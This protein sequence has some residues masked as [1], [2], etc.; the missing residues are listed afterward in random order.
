MHEEIIERSDG[1]VCPFVHTRARC[2]PRKV[3]QMRFTTNVLMVTLASTIVLG[4]A[5]T[6]HAQNDVQG[7]CSDPW[8]TKAIQELE[9]RPAIGSGEFGE[10]MT[11]L[12]I[13]TATTRGRTKSS[14]AKKRGES[15][16]KSYA[17]AQKKVAATSRLMRNQR[18]TFQP[19]TSWLNSATRY[20]LLQGNGILGNN[21]GMVIVNNSGNFRRGDKSIQH[22]F[23]LPD[24]RKLIVRDAPKTEPGKEEK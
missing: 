11:S 19:S 14:A 10:C 4:G 3:I 7:T 6:A 24:G 21:G 18:L 22:V 13:S 20:N 15:P 5:T 8:I 16:F 12:Y 1:C 9:G 2:R 17:D 23:D